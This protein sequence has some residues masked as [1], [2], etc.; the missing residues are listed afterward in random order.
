MGQKASTVPSGDV[1][2]QMCQS[3]STT[4]QKCIEGVRVQLHAFLTLELGVGVGHPH[5][6]ASAHWIA[7]CVVLL[8]RL[9]TVSLPAYPV[10]LHEWC[11]AS[12]GKYNGGYGAVDRNSR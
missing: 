5:T 8:A 11:S 3:F 7:G 10:T 12:N 1:R 2:V 4:P 9:N 6:P